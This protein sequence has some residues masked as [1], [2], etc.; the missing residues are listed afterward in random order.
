MM[1]SHWTAAGRSRLRSSRLLNPNVAPPIGGYALPRQYS[2]GA[3][4]VTRR[5]ELQ[6]VVAELRC[7]V[8]TGALGILRSVDL[9]RVGRV[10]ERLG[11]WIVRGGNRQ[12]GG[13]GSAGR[14]VQERDSRNPAPGG[15]H[16]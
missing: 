2:A 13:P 8:C 10:T 12:L 15:Q 11:N 6:T 3:P 1:A 4:G 7:A 5:S 14:D 16:K 9:G